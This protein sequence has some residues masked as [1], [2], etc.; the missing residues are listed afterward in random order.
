MEFF[1]KSLSASTF[2]QIASRLIFAYD[3]TMSQQPHNRYPW[4][5]RIQAAGVSTLEEALFCHKVGVDAIGFTLGLPD[6]PHD[7]L[8]PEKAGAIAADL[9]PGVLPVVITYVDRANAACEL[10]IITKSEAIQFH[11][12]IS[13]KD[14]VNFR[15]N[16]PDVRTIGR[17]T[18]VGQESIEEAASFKQPLWD[19]IILDSLD[20]RTGRKGATGL[21]HDWSLSTEIVRIASVPVI[22]AGGLN[23]EN[24]A[25]AI[26]KVQPHGVDAHTGLEDGNGTRSFDKIKAF[27]EAALDAFESLSP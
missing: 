10:A 17:V 7:G 1:D 19:A 27:A 5:P 16:C 15:R 14:L 23:P 22:L 26:R 6:G 21:T 13:E 20:P 2:V 11:G 4:P 3:G 24:V 18:V 8:T 25:E 12:G 9:P